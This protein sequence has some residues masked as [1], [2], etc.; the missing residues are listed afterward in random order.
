MHDLVLV[1]KKPHPIV[2]RVFKIGL[3]L[4]FEDAYLVEIGNFRWG[5]KLHNY[6]VMYLVYYVPNDM[7]HCRARGG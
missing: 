1:I 6:K 7:F 5:V 3:V 2:A 4:Y